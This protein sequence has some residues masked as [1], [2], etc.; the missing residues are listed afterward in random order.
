MVFMLHQDEL[1][2]WTQSNADKKRVS[3]RAEALRGLRKKEV[4]DEY[5]ALAWQFDSI[6]RKEWDEEDAC[7]EG[8]L[9]KVA[10]TPAQNFYRFSDKSFFIM[11]EE[12][13]NGELFA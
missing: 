8:F 4:F 2:S 11:E 7:Q 9:I 5:E 10:D 13:D 6:G 12:R 3:D 1:Y